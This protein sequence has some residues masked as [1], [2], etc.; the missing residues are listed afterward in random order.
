MSDVV[1]YARD[2]GFFFAPL[3]AAFAQALREGA[4]PLWNPMIGSGIPMAADPNSAV[5]FPPTLLFL[6]RPFSAGAR[7]AHLVWC[8][9]FPV[10]AFAALRR[11]GQSRAS[12]G[13]CAFVLAICGPAMTLA[14][15]PTTAWAVA[16]FL[17]LVAVW[18]AERGSSGRALAGAAVLVGLI[19]LAGE[20]AI[21]LEILAL[22]L[23]FRSLSRGRA[24]WGRTIAGI[25]IGVAI[26][27]P[28]IVTA[29]QLIG[30]TVRGS[31]LAVSSGAA[32]YSVRPARLLSIAWPGLFGDVHSGSP[33]GFWGT[34]FFDAG[35]PYIS[36]LAVGTVTWILLAAAMRDARGRRL[37]AVAATATLLSFGRH[38]PGGSAL[39]GLPGLSL[40]RYPEKW[41]FLALIAAIGAAGFALDLIRRD[42]R[43]AARLT[44]V[45]AAVAAAASL[46]AGAAV[47][48]CPARVLD[49][50]AAMRI[51]APQFLGSG[52][53]I[54]AAI[55]R[56]CL[57][58]GAF[59]A[60]ACLVAIALRGRP[61]RMFA[62]LVVLL[63]LDLFPRTWDSVPLESRDYFDVP[64]AAVAAVRAVGGRFSYAEEAE[65]AAD[66]LRPMRPAIW[67]VAFAGN[68]DIDRF[69]PR[70]SFFYGRAVA[71]IPF[72]D[73]R[74]SSLLQLADVG[75]VSTIDPS[76]SGV[77][78]PLFR[79]SLRRTVYR[80]EGGERFRVMANVIGA[81]SEEEAR[82][83]ALSP[84]I[85]LRQTVVVEG[86]PPLIAAK[87]AW[88][89]AA[90][91]RRA[92]REAVSAS[93]EAGGYLM[94]AETYDPHWRATVDGRSATLVPADFFFQAVALPPGIHR[95]EFVYYDTA[96]AVS[97]GVSLA[98]LLG[99]VLLLRK[100]ATRG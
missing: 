7:A 10:L 85:D 69:S 5:F 20:P 28:Q 100:T 53:A 47:A 48:I 84:G 4:S 38:V 58:T 13:A 16:G 22:A 33:A 29:A 95:V 36:T 2:L 12:A 57:V 59:A 91:A 81:G 32:Y 43:A 74:K 82:V 72:S 60:I 19:V 66:P 61:G 49:A 64:P 35:T 63:V 17:P 9:A 25:G 70:R 54:L 56:D 88:S 8:G 52:L 80:M 92:D 46:S 78:R 68:N 39:L 99:V 24:G 6:L 51:V 96:L 50:L 67:G 34:S 89:V 23:L 75:A 65:V 93:S 14:S 55:R 71:S 94:R 86:A 98:A 26:A 62:A 3:R 27:A 97:M 76:A 44:A 77:L 42:D 41:L 18:G 45:S 31:G 30:K 40:F 90:I 21:T 11:L 87:G 15:L 37:L 73:V 1:F 79:T 83:L